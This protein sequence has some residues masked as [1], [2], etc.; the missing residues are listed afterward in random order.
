MPWR[1]SSIMSQRHEFVLLASQPKAN[2]KQLCRRFGIS[3]PTGYKWWA[4]YRSAGETGLVDQSRR[5]HHSP[6]QTDPEK[7]TA[8]ISL[9]RKHPA[10]GGRKLQQR[11]LDLGHRDLPAAS[12][13]TNILARHELLDPQESSKH[14]AFQRFEHPA[15]NDLWQMD[16]KG[17]F[18]LAPGRC[19]PLTIVDDHSRFAIALQACARNTKNITQTA[20]MQAFRRYGLPFRISCDNGPP[21][22]SSGRGHFTQLAIWLMRLGIVVAYA[23]PHHPQTNGKDERFN[24][25]FEV[26]VLR[27]QRATTLAQWQRHFDAWRYVY[28]NERPHEALHMKVPATRYQP[29]AREYPERLAAIEYGPTDIVRKVRHAGHIKYQGREIHVGAAFYGLHIALRPTTTDGQF[30]VFFCQIQIGL[31]DLSQPKN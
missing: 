11:L 5:P 8:I 13:I 4:R 14:R 15:P 20:L 12:T 29:S 19:Y 16:F 31:L 2:M 30:A 26:E 22:G 3:R 17:D 23:R 18:A 24:R 25:T 6:N 9:R 10:W 1:I 7:E 28:N 27:Y 21:W